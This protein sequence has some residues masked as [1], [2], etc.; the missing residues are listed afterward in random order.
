MRLTIASL[1]DQKWGEDTP[2]LSLIDFSFALRKARNELIFQGW[3]ERLE[4]GELDNEGLIPMLKAVMAY[5]EAWD[6]IL[7]P[8]ET[9]EIVRRDMHPLYYNWDYHAKRGG[10]EVKIA[11]DTYGLNAGRHIELISISSLRIATNEE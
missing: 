1:I 8:G 6:A 4:R 2:N 11:Y 10:R 5:L 9:Q 7:P 3:S